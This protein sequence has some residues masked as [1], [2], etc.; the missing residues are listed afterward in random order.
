MQP[1]K[2]AVLTC[3]VA[4]NILLRAIVQNQVFTGFQTNVI[5]VESIRNSAY[6]VR[7]SLTLYSVTSVTVVF[8]TV[9]HVC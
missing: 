5:K 4:S 3:S 2:L 1:Q 6:F 7:N 9:W 8:P